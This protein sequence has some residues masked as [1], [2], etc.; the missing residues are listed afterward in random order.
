MLCL[1]YTLFAVTPKLLNWLE[2]CGLP[3]YQIHASGHI[4]PAELKRAISEIN[5]QKVYVVHCDRP[6]LLA[7]YARDLGIETICPEEGVEY[8][9]G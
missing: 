1:F 6:K 2:T 5:P 9:V 8:S 4:N 3:L 7:A